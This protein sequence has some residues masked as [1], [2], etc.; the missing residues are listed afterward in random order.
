MSMLSPAPE[1]C[2]DLVLTRV[3][4]RYARDHHMTNTEA[5]RHIMKT[6]TYALLVNPD[7]LQCYESAESIRGLLDDEERGDWDAW[8]KV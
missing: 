3:A 6:E 8:L 5:L 7:S 1:L 4:E 2:A